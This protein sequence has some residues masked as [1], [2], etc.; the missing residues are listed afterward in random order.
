MSTGDRK[1]TQI[2]RLAGI[3]PECITEIYTDSGKVEHIV[4]FDKLRHILGDSALQETSENSRERYMFTWPGKSASRRLADSP[5]NMTLRPCKEESVNFEST[6]NIYIEG[7]NLYAL[8]LLRETYCGKIKMIYIDPPYNTGSDFIYNDNF[9]ISNRDFDLIDGNRDESG[10]MM[11]TNV[12]S[13][14]RFHTDWLN[15]I[16]PRLIISRDL[17]SETGAIFV[18]IDDNEFANLRKICD[19]VFGERN[20]VSN[21]VWQSTAGSNTGTGIVTVT[22]NILVYAKNIN[23]VNLEGQLTNDESFQYEDEHVATRGKY[24][25]DKLDR[26]RVGEHYSESLNYPITM[27][28][29]SIRY[30]GGTKERNSEGWNYL[31]S[32]SK[33]E[34]GIEEDYIVFKKGKDGWNVYNKRYSKVDNEGKPKSK[35]TPYRNLINSDQYNTAQGT[36]E[37]RELFGYRPFDF[38][39]PSGLIK[40]LI[41][42]IA[43]SDED[44]IVMDFFSGS[45]S[46]AQAVIETNKQFGGK[47]RFI[48]VQAPEPTPENS[49][50]YQNGC[51]TI[52][53]V[54]KKRIKLVGERMTGGQRTLIP[55]DVDV[56]FRVFKLDS[57][58]MADVYYSPQTFRKDRLDV[59]IDNIK[60]DRSG[61]DLLIQIMLEL[62]I[63]LS[64]EIKTEMID[65]KA[66]FT[67]DDG[68]LVAC[69]DSNL[70]DHIFSE[71]A[72]RKPRHAAFRDSSMSSDSVA[73][74]FSQIF[75]AFSSDTKTIVL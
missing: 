69:F 60:K 32:K 30:P 67:V 20:F 70:N 40:N 39:K 3:I 61:E 23:E 7:D 15:M 49:E 47:R 19:E 13:N 74:N 5:S 41:Q 46:T 9:S 44:A 53:D 14:G 59:A 33:V 27:P 17:L 10:N 75:E 51:K 64:A 62:G 63:E 31:W 1:D 66:I 43:R 54:G 73:Y 35:S 37:L 36:S 8:K 28:D 56:G 65:G 45:A 11:V 48:L 24:S 52:C 6:K 4:D 26:R 58:N 38:P 55:D 16:Y 57:S 12:R 2:E 71:I 42:M 50:A 72:R 68:Y 21:I 25:L 34:W 18:S 22:E 29:G